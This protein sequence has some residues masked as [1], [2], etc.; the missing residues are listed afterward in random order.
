MGRSAIRI[1]N[2]PQPVR[3]RVSEE[4]WRLRCELAAELFFSARVQYKNPVVQGE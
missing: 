1:R 2:K 4:E 3:E